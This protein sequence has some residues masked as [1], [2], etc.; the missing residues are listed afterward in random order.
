MLMRWT[1]I[2]SLSLLA[3]CVDMGKVGMHPQLKEY[4]FSAN[5]DTTYRCLDSEA[6]LNGLRLEEGDPFPSG[7]RRFELYDKADVMVAHL[8]ISPFGQPADKQTNVDLFYGRNDPQSERQLMTM[9]ARCQKE[10][11]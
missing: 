5:T 6:T 4:W 1:L 7:S 3:G 8:D 10:L 2:F 11:D 9:M